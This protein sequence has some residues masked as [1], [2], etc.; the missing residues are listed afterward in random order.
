MSKKGVD[1][2]FIKGS[3][4]DACACLHCVTLILTAKHPGRGH[5][6][7]HIS[8]DIAFLAW[9]YWQVARDG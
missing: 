5:T 7:I 6:E 2:S 8:G 1:I 9:Q 3:E 4:T